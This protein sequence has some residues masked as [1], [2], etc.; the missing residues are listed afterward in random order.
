[1]A[2]RGEK[3][4]EAGSYLGMLCKF[5]LKADSRHGIFPGVGFDLFLPAKRSTD[6]LKSL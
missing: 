6:I 3:G 4:M 5:S 2:S 1:M